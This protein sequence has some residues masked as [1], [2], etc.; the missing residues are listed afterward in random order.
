MEVHVYYCKVQPLYNNQL[1]AHD[2]WLKSEALP[3]TNFDYLVSVL[4]LTLIKRSKYGLSD[5]ENKWIS[6][7]KLQLGIV[8]FKKM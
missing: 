7:Y 4:Y 5:A 6:A 1:I 8:F 3:K 2:F